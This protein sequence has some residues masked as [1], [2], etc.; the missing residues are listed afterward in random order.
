MSEKELSQWRTEQRKIRKKFMQRENRLRK[1]A[2]VEEIQKMLL[3]LDSSLKLQKQKTKSTTFTAA[4]AAKKDEVRKS[5]DSELNPNEV[6]MNAVDSS[7]NMFEPLFELT[8]EVLSDNVFANVSE[9]DESVPSVGWL[10]SPKPEDAISNEG[11]EVQAVP[12][13]IC[14]ADANIL[15]CDGDENY[16]GTI[17][18]STMDTDTD[19]VPLEVVGDDARFT[20]VL[21]DDQ[22]FIHPNL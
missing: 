5:S 1:K 8:D 6:G 12:E 22:S 11:L 14:G 20:S 4:A 2:R 18:T 9:T 7:Q 21:N 17:F 15:P 10:G 13:E 19:D 16:F 3:E